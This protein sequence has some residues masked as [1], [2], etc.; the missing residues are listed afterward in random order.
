M[1]GVTGQAITFPAPT[2]TITSDS[3][4]LSTN[5][6][7]VSNQVVGLYADISAWASNPSPAKATPIINN[8]N[9]VLG[10]IA[11][12]LGSLPKGGGGGG[13]GGLFG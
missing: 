12:L 9:G 8:I 3:P 4:A 10:G 6:A 5:V 2:T 7:A 1:I 11:G 13:G